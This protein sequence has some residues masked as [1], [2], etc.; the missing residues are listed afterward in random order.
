MIYKLFGSRIRYIASVF[1]NGI[2]N[3]ILGKEEKKYKNIHLLPNSSF[4][5]EKFM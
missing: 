3:K 1:K 2:I 4:N 5:K